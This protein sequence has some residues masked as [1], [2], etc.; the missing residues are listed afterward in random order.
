M[1][2]LNNYLYKNSEIIVYYYLIEILSKL[3]F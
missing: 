1:M 3:G 2:L